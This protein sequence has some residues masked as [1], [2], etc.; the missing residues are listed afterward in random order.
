MLSTVHNN[1]GEKPQI[2]RVFQFTRQQ[3]SRR[4]LHGDRPPGRQPCRWRAWSLPPRPGRIQLKPAM[5]YDIASRFGQTVNPMLQQLSGVWHPGAGSPAAG[6][7]PASQGMAGASSRIAGRAQIYPCIQVAAPD[8]TRQ[9]S[10]SPM[11]GR[12]I[13]RAAM[14]P[15]SCAGRTASRWARDEPRRYRSHQPLQGQHDA[16]GQLEGPGTLVYAFRGD[17]TKEFVDVFQAWRKA[18]GQG[19]AK[20]Q[21]EHIQQMP[22]RSRAHTVSGQRAD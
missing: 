8:D 1:C 6:T 11:G 22:A 9:A 12:W 10:A 19:P 17:L 5:V 2:G 21:V 15:S 20:I 18:G 16:R 14:A 4:V 7:A 13:P 3:F